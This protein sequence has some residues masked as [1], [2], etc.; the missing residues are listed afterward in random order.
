MAL[1]KR[2]GSPMGKKTIAKWPGKFH[3]TGKNCLLRCRK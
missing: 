2:L 3:N 1:V